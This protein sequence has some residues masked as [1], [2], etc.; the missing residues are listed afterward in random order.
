M[1]L[2]LPSVDQNNFPTCVF[3]GITEKTARLLSRLWGSH[4]THYQAPSLQKEIGPQD[5]GDNKSPWR[6][7]KILTT[8]DTALPNC[9]GA[10]EGS[11]MSGQCQRQ[12]P[13]R[14]GCGMAVYVALDHDKTALWDEE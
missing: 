8:L 3:P 10:L 7:G 6:A 11:T 2:P 9:F 12:D 14:P 13:R 4:I 1:P 5:S